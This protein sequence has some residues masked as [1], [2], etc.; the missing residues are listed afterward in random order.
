M[1]SKA[2]KRLK[3]YS[4]HPYSH[5]QKKKKKNQNPPFYFFQYPWLVNY[6]RKQGNLENLAWNRIWK[7]VLASK[8]RQ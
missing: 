2:R 8:H 1:L 3:E 7:D 6:V 4:T 5:L